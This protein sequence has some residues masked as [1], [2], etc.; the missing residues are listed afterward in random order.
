MKATVADAFVQLH[1]AVLRLELA[2]QEG[3]LLG[4]RLRCRE[5]R[6]LAAL[7]DAAGG[8]EAA[9]ALMADHNRT[10]S[11]DHGRPW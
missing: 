6:A 3:N 4:S 10:F 2:A 11:H 9:E 5:A 1:K 7:L 8:G